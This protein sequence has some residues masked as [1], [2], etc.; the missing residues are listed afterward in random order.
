MISRE[1]FVKD[2]LS[3]VVSNLYRSDENHI[4]TIDQNLGIVWFWGVI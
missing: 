1:S 2:Q 3:L 4:E